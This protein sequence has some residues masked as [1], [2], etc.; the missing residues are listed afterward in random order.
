MQGVILLEFHVSGCHQL[1]L[2]CPH[3][4]IVKGDYTDPKT[5]L[6]YIL[7]NNPLNLLRIDFTKVD[8]YK[9][10]KENI[11]ILKHVLTNFRQAFVT[12]NL[13]I[14]TKAKIIVDK[15]FY[16]YGIPVH[17]H[18]DKDWCFNNEIMEHLCTMYGVKQSTTKPNNPHDNVRSLTV[19]SLTSNH[20]QKSRR[21]I[22]ICIY[23]H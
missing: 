10:S 18:S 15:W 19:Q 21:A 5:Q 6:G 14:L 12:P 23:H 9:D 22:G 16:S 4:Q 11:L 7:A 1:F 13:K 2:K 20:Y 17:V 8:P 3:C